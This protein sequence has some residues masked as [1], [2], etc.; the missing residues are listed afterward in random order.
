MTSTS[1]KITGVHGLHKHTGLSNGSVSGSPKNVRLSLEFLLAGN[2]TF[3][4]TPGK[5]NYPIIGIFQGN[6]K[7]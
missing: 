3:R 2:V 4:I 6:T 7:K 1:N 5:K